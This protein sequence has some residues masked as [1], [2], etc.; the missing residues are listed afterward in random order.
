MNKRQSPQR[1][2]VRIP[3][4]L[5]ALVA[6]GNTLSPVSLPRLTW[7]DHMRFYATSSSV[8]W[9]PVPLLPCSCYRECPFLH[10]WSI[11]MIK[12]NQYLV[13]SS[14]LSSYSLQQQLEILSRFLHRFDCTSSLEFLLNWN[15][16]CRLI[17]TSPIPPHARN[18]LHL[19]LTAKSKFSS[20]MSSFYPA[21]NR[22]VN[23]FK[24]FSKWPIFWHSYF[25]LFPV[26]YIC[27]DR[28]PWTS[29]RNI[30]KSAQISYITSC[31]HNK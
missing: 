4:P 12:S 13:R 7:G 28:R 6:D 21:V 29:W 31:C 9:L 27:S 15:Y 5:V 14:S 19:I 10:A 8:L 17:R 30:T 23:P 26:E 3:F 22:R 25:R 18:I 2:K 20:T 1:S 11:S 16:D 24:K